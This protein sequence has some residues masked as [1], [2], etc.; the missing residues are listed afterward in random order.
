M[1]H[2][3]RHTAVCL[4]L[5]LLIGGIGGFWILPALQPV[6]GIEAMPFLVAGALAAVFVLVL[7][8]ADRIGLSR[9]TH[10]IRSADVAEREGLSTEAEEAY[11][12]ALTA[13][14]RFWVSS[15]DRRSVMIQLA[16]RLARFYLAQAHLAPAAEDFITQYLSAR[17]GDEEVAEQWVRLAEGRGGL[18]EEHQDLAARL[19]SAHPRNAAVQHA[20]ARLYLALERTDYPAL[21][22]YRRVCDA[23]GCAPAEF[24]GDLAR[25]LRKDRRSDEWAQQ[26]YSQAQGLGPAP[27][28]SVSR[29]EPEL[30]RIEPDVSEADEDEI[31]RPTEEWDQPEAAFRMAGET[32]ALEEEDT[33][34]RASLLTGGRSAVRPY[35]DRLATVAGSALHM[36]LEGIRR[37]VRG[38]WKSA[39]FAFQFRAVRYALGVL[40]VTG[41]VGSGIWMAMDA[42]DLFDRGSLPPAGSQRSA[43]ATAAAMDPYT[44]QVAAYLKQEYAFKL[45]EELKGKGLDAYWTETSSGGKLWYQVRISHFSDQQTARDYG[46]N[47]KWQGLI[48]DFYVTNYVR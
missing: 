25:L 20:L 44:L 13:L 19:G 21:R 16:G 23:Q 46:R 32:D 22:T 34:A 24:C 8:A 36:V 9:V 17:P 12:K 40:L 43:P 26:I 7:W 18:Q 41:V 11:R 14:D 1:T 31:P 47:L 42:L 48:D 2:F 33:E 4:W 30:P 35:L 10:L 6:L 5:S 39:R 15:A 38:F 45:V 37:F 29:R 3:L 27:D 28:L